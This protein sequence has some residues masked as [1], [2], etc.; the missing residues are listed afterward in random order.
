MVPNG[1]PF[2]GLLPRRRTV[3]GVRTASTGFIC[4]YRPDVATLGPAV[5]S[6]LYGPCITPHHG[7]IEWGFDMESFCILCSE[8]VNNIA[9]VA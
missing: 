8:E 6:R 3:K 9:I 7:S 5:A 4:F 1:A 2:Q